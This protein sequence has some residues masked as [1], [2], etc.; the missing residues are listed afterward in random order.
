ELN[1]RDSRHWP[2]FGSVIDYLRQQTERSAPTVPRNIALPFPFSSRSPQYQRG[3]PYGGFLGPSYNPVWTE[4]E[5]TATM[6]LPRW[7]GAADEEVADPYLGIS[8]DSRFVVSSEASQDLTLDRL[9]RRR[10]LLQQFDDVRRQTD[11]SPATRSYDRY[12]GMAYSLLTSP[13]I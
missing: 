7:Q 5:G 6:T 12:H 1:P 4:F 13:E 8:R 11:A 10:S 2:S 3:G 9:N